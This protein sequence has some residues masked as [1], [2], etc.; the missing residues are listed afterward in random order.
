MRIL[1][2][3]SGGGGVVLVVVLALLA[4]GHGAGISTALA[5]LLIALALVVALALGGLVAFLVYRGRQAHPAT[6]YRA[7]VVH[8]RSDSPVQANPPDLTVA[9][10]EAPAPV[11]NN[12]FG[13]TPEEVA[14]ILRRQQAG[15]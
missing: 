9:A 1:I 3:T 5:V 8:D 6:P 14:E 7:E 15:Q 4:G 2:Q 13:V 12:F 11:V 10:I